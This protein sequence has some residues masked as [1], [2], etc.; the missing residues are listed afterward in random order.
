VIPIEEYL[1]STYEP[2]AITS[3]AGLKNAT[4]A[5]A[6]RIR[7]ADICVATAADGLRE[8]KTGLLT[9]VNPVFEVPLFEVLR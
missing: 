6:S 7:V 2:T 4:G 3:T 1:T 8:V 5:G 9:T